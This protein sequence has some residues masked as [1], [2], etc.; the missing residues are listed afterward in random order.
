MVSGAVTSTI[1]SYVP[2]WR[3]CSMNRV[4]CL[5]PLQHCE[6][7]E[8]LYLRRN[9]IMS[10]NE[11]E[12]LKGLKN[13]KI[14]WIDDNPCTV[15]INHRPRVLKILPK[16]TR[17]DDKPVTIDDLH[18]MRELTRR[19]GSS[20]F[21]IPCGDERR[22]VDTVLPNNSQLLDLTSSHSSST[23]NEE[24]ASYK[25]MQSSMYESV[26]NDDVLEDDTSWQDFSLDEKRALVPDG[27]VYL[28]SSCEGPVNSL[29]Y[30]SL[31]EGSQS[32][33]H[34]NSCKMPIPVH[35]RSV[36]LP[37]RRNNTVSLSPLKNVQR[38][39]KIMSA[40]NVLLD[41]LDADGLRRVVDE[42]QRRIK[43]QR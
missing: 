25:S 34:I 29:M 6:K 9:E 30:Q 31:Y 19:R 32:A 11:L 1:S 13:L 5:S 39:E 17:L 27:S 7:L 8:E 23:L 18:E 28:L 16:L 24:V 14:L 41:E 37:R 40:I 38:R 10:L 35:Q 36:S 22:I 2:G 21:E 3:T 15:G 20:E 33:R 12:H 43:K 26:I 4:S 42:A